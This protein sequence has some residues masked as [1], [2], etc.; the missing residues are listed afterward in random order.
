MSY[1]LI[2]NSLGEIIYR[3]N[4]VSIE[5]LPTKERRFVRSVYARQDAIPPEL[6]SRFRVY[7]TQRTPR[8]KPRCVL[9]TEF[10]QF[11]AEKPFWKELSAAA[12]A[13]GADRWVMHESEH[14]DKSS[15][16]GGK[17]WVC[18]TRHGEM[19]RQMELSWPVSNSLAKFRAQVRRKAK[20]TQRIWDKAG[21]NVI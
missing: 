17:T 20:E 3:D 18:G 8:S 10:L 14:L 15:T 13:S 9:V 1:Y 2:I 5:D 19:E 7:G 21:V 6:G 16:D 4:L 11:C 12:R